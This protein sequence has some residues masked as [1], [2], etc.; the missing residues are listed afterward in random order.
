MSQVYNAVSAP[1]KC[2][3]AHFTSRFGQNAV[4][5]SRNGA[6]RAISERSDAVLRSDVTY[7]ILGTSDRTN[8]SINLTF[9]RDLCQDIRAAMRK[10]KVGNSLSFARELTFSKA[11]TEWKILRRRHIIVNPVRTA[12]SVSRYGNVPVACRAVNLSRGQQSRH[13]R[14][15]G[16]SPLR[17][18]V[19]SVTAAR[20]DGLLR[21]YDMQKLLIVLVGG[22]ESVVTDLQHVRLL[23]VSFSHHLSARR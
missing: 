17:L 6:L 10:R 7:V 5:S 22:N 8:R 2:H 19:R 9:A 21:L 12:G 16:A 23:N 18:V 3:K 15:H 13:I 20:R 4:A 11:R 14:A 1:Y